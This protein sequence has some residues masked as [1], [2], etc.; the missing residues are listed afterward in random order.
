MSVVLAARSAS[1]AEERDDHEDRPHHE[2]YPEQR[3]H[4]RFVPSSIVGCLTSLHAR[5]V[6]RADVN[7]RCSRDGDGAEPRAALGGAGDRGRA[8]LDGRRSRADGER[9][10]RCRGRDLRHRDADRD[11]G[12]GRPRRLLPAR[13]EMRC[14]RPRHLGRAGRADTARLGLSRRRSRRA[15]LVVSRVR[16]LGARLDLHGRTHRERGRN[17]QRSRPADVRA[18]GPVAG[19]TPPL[20]GRARRRA[21][22]GCGPQMGR[23]PCVRSLDTPSPG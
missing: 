1:E 4:Q 22:R 10:P 11:R 14:H 19:T 18:A 20:P 17:R 2:C 8:S 13:G 6:R 7:V 16:G 15:D 23:L 21:D 12:R 9:L 3:P 5:T